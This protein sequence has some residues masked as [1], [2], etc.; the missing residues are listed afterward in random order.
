MLFRFLKYT[1]EDEHDRHIGAEFIAGII[2]K[3]GFD[4]FFNIIKNSKGINIEVEDCL[5]TIDDIV[6]H[7]DGG[8]DD[9]FVCNIYCI[10]Y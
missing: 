10:G 8:E 9:L 4:Q 3:E 7:Y 5:Y 6:F 1:F 2:I